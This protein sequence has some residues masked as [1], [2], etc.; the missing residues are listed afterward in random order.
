MKTIIL[1]FICVLFIN[2]ESDNVYVSDVKEECARITSYG[3]DS[4]GNFIIIRTSYSL[5]RYKVDNYSMYIGK[6]SIC[7]TKG[8]TQQPL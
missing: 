5:E 6:Y 3:E 2:C 1:L 7:D 4:R 8:L